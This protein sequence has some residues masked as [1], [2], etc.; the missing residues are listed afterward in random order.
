MHPRWLRRSVSIRVD[1]PSR[2]SAKFRFPRLHIE[3]LEER[4]APA[5]LVAAYAFDEGTGTT[6]AD[7]SGRQRSPASLGPVCFLVRSDRCRPTRSIS[8]T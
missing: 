2:W 7:A 3:A 5:G 4:L 6:V 1:R 8:K